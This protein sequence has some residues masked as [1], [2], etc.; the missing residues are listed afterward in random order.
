MSVAGRGQVVLVKM[1][2]CC[3][4]LLLALSPVSAQPFFD[5][6]IYESA[7]LSDSML[8]GVGLMT[9]I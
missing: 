9:Y 8:D 1:L 3:C 6:I 7:K 4:I 2:S 5:L